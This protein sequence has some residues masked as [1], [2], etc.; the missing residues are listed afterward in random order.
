MNNSEGLV[1]GIWLNHYRVINRVNRLL[2]GAGKIT[3]TSS[4]TA[5][6]N[7]IIAQARAIRAFSYVQLESLFST[8]MTNPGA[9]GVILL[10]DIPDTDAKLPRSTNQ[11]V[12]DFINADLDYARSVLAYSLPTNAS[13]RFY[14]DKGFVNAL[15]AR[16]N[17]YRGNYT[18]AKQ[19][20]QDVISNSGLTLTA[21]TQLQE[22]LLE[23]LPIQL[24]RLLYLLIKLQPGIPRFMEL[25][26]HLILIEI[27]GMIRLEEK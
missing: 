10:K 15:S 9:L 13:A 22:V 21:A 5:Q 17:A 12:Y 16:F 7:S 11:E 20:A 26:L 2:E 27:Y 6:Y 23:H 19:Y 8:D 3:P 4:E 24:L 25:S 18:L 14:V 1:S